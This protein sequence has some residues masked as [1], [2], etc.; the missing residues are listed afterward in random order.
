M[1]RVLRIHSVGAKSSEA[2]LDFPLFAG[3]DSKDYS[4]YCIVNKYT[5]EI[6]D[7][8]WFADAVRADSVTFVN[9]GPISKQGK[10]TLEKIKYVICS[11]PARK[12]I[13]D[14]GRAISPHILT[15]T[16]QRRDLVLVMQLARTLG[17]RPFIT[18]LHYPVGGLGENA[19]PLLQQAAMVIVFSNY[20][21]NDAEKHGVRAARIYP[22]IPEYALSLPEERR[23]AR[24]AVRYE[25]N[26]P[27]DATVIGMGARLAFWKGQRDIVKAFYSL[28]S[29][30]V[31][32]HNV[33]L[34]FCGSDYGDR[35]HLQAMIDRGPYAAR[36]KLLGMR[37]DMPRILAAWDIAAHPSRSEAFGIST[38]EASA[39]GLP[40]VGYDDGA[41]PEIV[42]HGKTGFAI[43]LIA[44]ENIE[45]LAQA[46]TLL[47]EN[48]DYLRERMGQ[49]GKARIQNVF[50]PDHK[51]SAREYTELL[52]D[53]HS[54]SDK[55]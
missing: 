9:C 25:F 52:W 39:A 55:Y 14:V 6:C 50:T 40:V 12:R 27:Q 23:A 16:Q 35:V 10:S 18:H 34:M 38:A 3:R 24:Q 31:N 8:K 29:S 11:V 44:E 7:A 19:I 26:V 43:P 17:G 32:H 41:F 54:R 15:S 46:L 20:M 30:L 21:K 51:R 42:E 45:G 37:S 33:Y 48:R 47:I 13:V 49:A 53:V 36:V 1:L 5:S 2:L 4:L 22:S 28:D